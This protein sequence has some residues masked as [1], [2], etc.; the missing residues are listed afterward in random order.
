MKQQEK[1]NSKRDN[2]LKKND[3]IG[4]YYE[5]PNGKIAYTYGWNGIKKEVSYYF[6]NE[7]PRVVTEN[8][9][10]TWKPRKDLKD[11]PN[12]KDPVLPYDF[13]LYYDL[14]RMSDLIDFV[15]QEDNPEVLQHLRSLVG[16]YKIKFINLEKGFKG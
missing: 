12:S 5:L 13:D 2:S 16:E 11:F 6:E 14:K 8:V 4:I 10:Q 15:D 3:T 1:Y 7:K 9:F